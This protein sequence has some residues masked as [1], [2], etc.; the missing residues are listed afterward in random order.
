MTMAEEEQR[1]IRLSDDAMTRAENIV[2]ALGFRGAVA[3]PCMRV[4]KVLAAY[5]KLEKNQPA[6]FVDEP[7][8]KTWVL[9]SEAKPLSKPQA[10]IGEAT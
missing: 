4:F 5:E 6:V 9:H 2:W 7:V 8:P 10:E 1:N 3:E